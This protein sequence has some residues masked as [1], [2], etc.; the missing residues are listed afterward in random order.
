[1]Q[2]AGKYFGMFLFLKYCKIKT[3]KILAAVLFSTGVHVFY[4]MRFVIES[5]LAAGDKAESDDS[6]EAAAGGSDWLHDWG[7]DTLTT[8]LQSKVCKLDVS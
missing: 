1:M 2:F 3:S 8:Q 4:I 7:V 5:D 6:K